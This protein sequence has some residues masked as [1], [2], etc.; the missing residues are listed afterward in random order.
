[1]DRFLHYLL[2]ALLLL[3]LSAMG[4]RSSHLSGAPFDLAIANEERLIEMLKKSGKISSYA[5]RS[6]A[7]TA[8]YAMLKQRQT[9]AMDAVQN[10]SESA[11]F[12][13]TVPQK[14]FGSANFGKGYQAK[15]HFRGGSSRPDSVED[16]I[17]EGGVNQAKLLTV[18]IEFPDYPH[19]S[20]L[21]ED[22]DMYY[23]NYTKAH[24]ESLLF[25]EDGFSGPNGETLIT[26]QG[27]Y[28]S[29]SGG[30]YGVTGAVAGWYMA[31]KNAAYYGAN[32]PYS[33]NDMAPRELVIEALLAAQA[34]PDV[35]L[36]DFDIE[37]RYDLDGDGDY[38]EPDGLV[39]H[40]QIIHSAIGEEAG[41][42]ALLEDA[43]WSHRW[44][45]DDILTLDDTATDITYWGGVMAAYDYTIQPIDAAPGVICHEYG[46]D[47]GLP[48]EYDTMYSGRGEPVS[49]WSLM[50]SGSWT[51]KVAGTQPTGFSAWSKEFLQDTMGG[52]WLTGARLHID[53]LNFRGERLLLDQAATKGTN[54]DVVRVD[55][56]DKKTVVVEPA[57]GEWVYFSGS[58][59]DLY[60]YLVTEVDLT[61]ATTAALEFKANI[62][63]EEDWDYAYVAVN[64]VAIPGN[65]TT[66]FDPFGQNFGNGITGKSDGWIDAVF[67]L[68]AYVGEVVSLEV[69]YITDAYV[70]NPG[71]YLDDI[72]IVTDGGSTLIADAESDLSDIGL[73]GFTR[74]MGY[75]LST[76][77]YLMEWRTHKGIDEG[78]KY[79]PVADQYMSSNE[80]LLLWYVDDYF[81]DNWVGV[82]PGDGYVGVVDADQRTLVWSD[83]YVASTRYQIHDAAF[84]LKP[85]SFLW[86]LLDDPEAGE[87]SM[88]DFFNRPKPFFS[89]H[90]SYLSPEIPDAGRVIPHYGLHIRV[91]AN[92]RDGTVGKVKLSRVPAI[93]TWREGGY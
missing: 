45:L 87:I 30:S 74:D 79:I 82:H 14:H 71:L 22:T 88:F 24:Y 38:W 2:S 7:E 17:Y 62:D 60:N 48:D 33:E 81:S 12:N 4:A 16:E 77:Y 34:D 72:S 49:Y 9:A 68:T 32:D 43:I 27:Y 36:A 47:L 91:I 35:N 69:Y 76:H 46:H 55:L 26:M 70:S 80:G 13:S 28:K 89:D 44:N 39:D 86:L 66:D 37:D 65:I 50:A 61:T 15:K 3:P 85:A 8:L 54:N 57:S 52:N 58:G 1:M 6:E 53:D 10:L 75:V 64:G 84:S 78:L 11:Q 21:P 40:V 41:G 18:L 42:G 93:G 20:V 92:S 83:G 5:S 25:N 56:P 59:D 23:E 29:Q 31:S 63:I 73:S 19:N 51:G 90:L 67:D